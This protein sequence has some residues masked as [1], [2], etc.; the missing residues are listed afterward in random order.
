MSVKGGLDLENWGR[1]ENLQL[2]IAEGWDKSRNR[3]TKF[4]GED[5]FYPLKMKAGGGGKTVAV[6]FLQS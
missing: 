4:R 5:L 2:T 3:G 6:G 1:G